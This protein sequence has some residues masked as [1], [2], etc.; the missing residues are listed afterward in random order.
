MKIKHILEEIKENA[1]YSA[2]NDSVVNKE[3]VYSKLDYLVFSAFNLMIWNVK[4]MICQKIGHKWED[5][6]HAGPDSGSI[7]MECSRCG[8]SYHHCLY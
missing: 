5:Y 3:C 2:Y 4:F 1:S 6:S 7:D 8:H